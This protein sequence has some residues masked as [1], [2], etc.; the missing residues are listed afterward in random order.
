MRW[1]RMLQLQEVNE[2]AYCCT[3]KGGHLRARSRPAQDT[4]KSDDEQFP[5]VV[6]RFTG[7]RIGD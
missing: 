6:A 3:T 5:E 2:K 7:A 1:D 4:Y